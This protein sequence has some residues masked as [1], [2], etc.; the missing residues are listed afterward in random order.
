V[1]INEPENFMSMTKKDYVLIAEQIKQ[2]LADCTRSDGAFPHR[3][4]I[5]VVARGLADKFGTLNPSFDSTR[6][7]LACEPCDNEYRTK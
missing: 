1:S 5:R 7:L 3:T 2:A 4:A 6:F